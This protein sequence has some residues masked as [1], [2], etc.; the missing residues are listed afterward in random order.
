MHELSVAEGILTTIEEHLGGVKQ[1]TRVNVILVALSGVS[2]ESL[3]F[4]FSEVAK[5][6]GFGSPEMH[7]QKVKAVAKCS[8]CGVEY[9]VQSFYTGCPACASTERSIASGYECNIESVE[10]EE[11]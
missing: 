5:Q 6:K 11:E 4:W 1:L 7:I 2:A 3:E 10:I 9:E 8:S